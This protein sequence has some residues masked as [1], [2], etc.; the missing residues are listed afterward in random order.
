[1]KAT[2]HF[3]ASHEF[4]KA[5]S[6]AHAGL[7]EECD[8]EGYTK[9]AEHHR[10]LAKLHADHA[11]H[12]SRMYAGAADK[13]ADDD[14]EKSRRE[15]ARTEVR[16]VVPD[17]PMLKAVVRTGGAPLQKPSVPMEFEKIFSVEEEE[18]DLLGKPVIG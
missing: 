12:H 9:M 8:N 18:R 10:T 7:A 3:K 5:A 16:R 4:H 15:I 2:D 11:D 1:M 13:A 6:A 14:I 17:N